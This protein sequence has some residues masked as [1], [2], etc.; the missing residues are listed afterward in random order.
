MSAFDMELGRVG[1]KS[2]RIALSLLI[3]LVLNSL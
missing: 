3:L 1:D 2:N